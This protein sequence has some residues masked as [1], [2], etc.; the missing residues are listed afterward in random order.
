MKRSVGARRP[1]TFYDHSAII[2]RRAPGAGRP[3]GRHRVSCP[4]TVADEAPMTPAVTLPPPPLHL[5]LAPRDLREAAIVVHPMHGADLPAAFL[6]ISPDGRELAFRTASEVR[7]TP[8]DE[9]RYV[10]F[11]EAQ[12]LGKPGGALAALP[13]VRLPRRAHRY[14]VWFIDGRQLAGETA[15]FRIDDLGLHL[16]HLDADRRVTRLFV[17]AAVVSAHQIGAELAQAL[18]AEGRIDPAAL[19]QAV[20]RQA[21]PKK[22]GQYLL[23]DHSV[24][25]EGLQQA[26]E[27]QQADPEEK[28]GRILVKAGLVT[29]RQLE[30]ALARQRQDGAAKLGAILVGMGAITAE[31]FQQKLAENVG[32]PFV[33]LSA[34]QP[35]REA[36]RLVPRDFAERHLL[37]PLM[38][39]GDYLIAAVADPMDGEAVSL[40]RF[41]TDKTVEPVVATRE[42]VAS[43]IERHYP[44]GAG[45]PEPAPAPP[46]APAA[47]GDE[48]LASEERLANQAPMVKLVNGMLTEAIDR[49]A[50]D[51]HV[52][53]GEHHVDILYRIDG[54]LVQA[55]RYP[56]G[57]LPALVSRI[58]IIGGMNIAEKRLPQDGQTRVLHQGRIVDL[59]LS[60]MPTIN[61]ESLVMRILDTRISLKSIKDL[62]FAERDREAF[63]ALLRKSYGM[64]LVTG[65]TGSG[66]ST[67]LYAALNEIRDGTINIV[68]VEDPVEYHIDGIMQVQVKSDIGYTF[69]EALRHILRHDPDVILVGEIRDQETARI[70]VRSA[71]TG[72]L[73]LSTLHTND[74]AGAVTR[75]RDMGIEPYL[76]ASTLLGVIAQRLVRRN[77]PHCVAPDPVDVA[78][79]AAVGA[80]EN[81]PFLRGR[82]CERCGRSGYAGRQAVY[83]LLLVTPAMQRLILAG[84]AHEEVHGQAIVDG[85]IPLTTNALLAAR[86]GATSLAE[87]YRTRLG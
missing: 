44:R 72:H 56:K 53:P 69:A 37:V 30:E 65:P 20:E 79:R 1:D 54:A 52:R 55:R 51:V 35:S 82:G 9:I 46:S 10:G 45:T 50:S 3:P 87:V 38:L 40:L 17:P 86:R 80:T 28:L 21:Y 66:K 33:R 78:M 74:A 77:C 63:S 43:A 15:G 16:F 59:R 8:L 68:T 23:E 4:A 75:L 36:L 57:L 22:I 60:A 18:A 70:A 41:I 47:P 34:I 24:T 11:T 62:G 73:V 49:R 64:I 84:A 29:P 71:L 42:D 26:L 27:R 83:E 67:T 25:A 76:L 19:A 6:G 81:E 31:A 2:R 14:R 12:P 85:M 61:G 5:G 13:D 7:R 32:L 58:K 39:H 48:Q